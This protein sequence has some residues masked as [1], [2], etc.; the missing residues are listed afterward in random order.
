MEK[1][2]I[3]RINTLAHKSKTIGLTIEESVEQDKLRKE[4]IA[5]WKQSLVSQLENTYIVTPDGKKT[6]VKKKSEK[7]KE[8]KK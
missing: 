3:E 8:E 7:K 5:A 6:K 2:K 4:Y 1:E